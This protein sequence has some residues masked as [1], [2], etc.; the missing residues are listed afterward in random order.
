MQVHHDPPI[1]SGPG[2]M[3]PRTRATPAEIDLLLQ[4]VIEQAVSVKLDTRIKKSQ[5]HWRLKFA[6][7]ESLQRLELYDQWCLQNHHCYC[8]FHREHPPVAV[9]TTAHTMEVDAVVVPEGAGRGLLKVAQEESKDLLITNTIESWLSEQEDVVRKPESIGSLSETASH[10]CCV[11]HCS[12]RI[13]IAQLHSQ[14]EAIKINQEKLFSFLAMG[15][16]FAYPPC[17]SKDPPV[18]SA[19]SI[20]DEA[21]EVFSLAPTTDSRAEENKKEREKSKERVF[22]SKNPQLVSEARKKEKKETLSE[23]RYTDPMIA[24]HVLLAHSLSG[25]AGASGAAQVNPILAGGGG[26]EDIVQPV[27]AKLRAIAKQTTYNGN[28][29]RW[30]VFKRQFSL[31]VGKN[32]LGDDEKLDAL[33][34]CLEGPIRDTW[35]ESHTDRA[36]FSN[37]LTYSELFALLEGRGS[38]LPED[39]YRT[40][41]T[42]FPNVPKAIFKGGSE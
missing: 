9:Y 26:I 3:L 41:L 37:P 34:E 13:E 30:A 10:V 8:R 39:H 42:S 36:G 40:F 15:R 12:C 24:A 21:T 16:S 25:A 14:N 35:I 18:G 32:K 17:P 5:E 1:S 20:A 6:K 29:R 33:L 19:C 28:P 4:N 31:W 11:H 22:E 23:K 27:R 7:I 2:E 38:G